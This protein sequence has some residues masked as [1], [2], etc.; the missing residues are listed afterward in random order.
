MSSKVCV[1]GKFSVTWYTAISLQEILLEATLTYYYLKCG[2]LSRHLQESLDRQTDGRTNKQILTLVGR[3]K[4][5][6]CGWGFVNMIAP[7]SSTGPGWLGWGCMTRVWL[8]PLYEVCGCCVDI[9]AVTVRSTWIG[10]GVLG[11][12]WPTVSE[13]NVILSL[14]IQWVCRQGVRALNQA[15]SQIKQ[16]VSWQWNSSLPGRLLRILRNFWSKGSIG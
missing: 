15:G 8:S 14:S 5:L 12:S 1:H 2:F 10:G 6:T 13:N 16:F 3:W 11:L 7:C 9:V 4:L